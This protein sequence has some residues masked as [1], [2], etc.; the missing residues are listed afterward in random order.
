MPGSFLVKEF[1]VSY[2]MR[3]WPRDCACRKHGYLAIYTTIGFTTVALSL[4]SAQK[5]VY[6]L[7]QKSQAAVKL[8]SDY[9]RICIATTV[10]WYGTWNWEKKSRSIRKRGKRKKHFWK[11]LNRDPALGDARHV[12]MHYVLVTPKW[13]RGVRRETDVNVDAFEWLTL[14]SIYNNKMLSPFYRVLVGRKRTFSGHVR[15]G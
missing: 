4:A 14:A 6:N 8:T 2:G 3:Y 15:R 10:S 12:N 7:F 5:V 9:F 11:T 1:Q 13:R